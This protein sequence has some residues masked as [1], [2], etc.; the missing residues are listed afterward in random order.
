MELPKQGFSHTCSFGTKSVALQFLSSTEK[1]RLAA[2]RFKIG[3]PIPA[4]L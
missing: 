3:A 2:P 4:S 1:T